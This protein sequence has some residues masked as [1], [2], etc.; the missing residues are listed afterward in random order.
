M[1]DQNNA[2][3]AT[4]FT[5]VTCLPFAVKFQRLGSVDQAGSGAY[6]RIGTVR[7]GG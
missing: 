1:R 3:R 7:H 5:V 4:I 6:R 2:I